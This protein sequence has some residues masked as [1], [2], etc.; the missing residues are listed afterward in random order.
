[1]LA[2]QRSQ[3]SGI[4]GDLGIG[5]SLTDLLRPHQGLA[6]SGLHGLCLGCGGRWLGLIPP[7]EP[8]NPAGG[9]HQALLAR[10]IRMALGTYLNVNR[11]GCRAGFELV[12]TGTLDRELVVVG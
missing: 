8:V 1:M 4:P 10:E 6:E 7:A 11:G 9:V 12:A 2:P 5:E 3:L